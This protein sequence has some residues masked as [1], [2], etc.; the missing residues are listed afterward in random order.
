[1]NSQRTITKHMASPINTFVSDD[2][3][4]SE[5][6]NRNLA[7]ASRDFAERDTAYIRAL[8]GPL[9]KRRMAPPLLREPKLPADF[10]AKAA[11]LD[12]EIGERR[13]A[14]SRERLLSLGRKRFTELLALDATARQSQ[15]IIGTKTD[16]TAW[17]S[18]AYSFGAA[19]ALV[20]EVGKRSSAEFNSG[21][22]ADRQSAS[23]IE[24]F[25]SLWK[26]YYHNPQA[27]QAVYAFRDA[28]ERLVFGQ[29][30][31][32]RLSDDGRIRSR[33]E[34]KRFVDWLP[35]VERPCFR[36]VIERPL[37][38]LL[39]WLTA[40]NAPP[41]NPAKAASYWFGVRAPSAEQIKLC[42]A[43]FDGFLLGHQSWSLWSY[44]GNRTRQIV[45]VEQLEEWRTQLT[46][47]YRSVTAFHAV[48]SEGF[49]KTVGN[50]DGGHFQFDRTGYRSFIDR[51][52]RWLEDRVSALMALTVDEVMP[53]ATVARFSDGWILCDGKP[54]SAITEKVTAKLNALFDGA[55]F[56]VT[57]EE[58][59]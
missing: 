35:V 30:L 21:A 29:S 19:N 23:R 12:N 50:V 24:S 4:G 44:V 51:A 16:L 46:K 5:Q 1:M 2:Q 15:R 37:W 39:A 36:V 26:C 9:Q 14:L 54:K 49:Y 52:V 59:N 25:D 41:L 3:T 57:M 6:H 17:E 34:A 22:D 13:V 32:E 11:A 48:T 38:H 20:A 33:L 27:V 31:L 45:D 7:I 47:G 55:K 18:V 42:A 58:T 56:Q 53:G 10:E 8:N 28:F 43:V 40:E